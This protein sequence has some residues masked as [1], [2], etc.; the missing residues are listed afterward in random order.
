M[1]RTP[2]G[3]VAVRAHSN[4]AHRAEFPGPATSLLTP[5]ARFTTLRPMHR[6]TLPLVALLAT[7]LLA[8]NEAGPAVL[9]PYVAF[10]ELCARHDSILAANAGSLIEDFRTA[11]NATWRPVAIAGEEEPTLELRKEGDRTV[12][13]ITA[14][15]NGKAL[16]AIG[17][18]L[19]GDTRF[20]MVA[21]SDADEP[22]DLSILLGPVAE[23]PGFQFGGYRNTR[24]LLWT[25][26]GE[27]GA[28]H[29]VELPVKTFITPRA[30]H[31]VRL[32][33]AG[34]ELIATVDGK[35][36]GRA[37]L[38]DRFDLK[39][40]LQPAIYCYGTTILVD[41]FAVLRP[42]T[43]N[44]ATAWQKCFG[45]LTRADVDRKIAELIALLDHENSAVR[46]GAQQLLIKAGPLAAPAVGAALKT[47]TL[48]QRLRAREILGAN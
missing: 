37:K 11:S 29:A 6:W 26:A 21:A 12:L 45:D 40:P 13:A 20:E 44:P 27:T 43:S 1:S 32:D 14:T 18:A 33:L 9:Q 47:G 7:P 5:R 48:E 46:D 42:Q 34:R 24:N 10:A 35:E 30:W 15:E 31:T 22:C 2:R 8:G 17:P 38:S 3:G 36:L 25:D 23:G 16:V 28:W 19:T 39:Q 4:T 41:R